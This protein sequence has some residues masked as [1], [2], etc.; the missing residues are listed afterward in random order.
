M[1]IVCRKNLIQND[2]IDCKIITLEEEKKVFL[3]E[4]VNRSQCFEIQN[5]LGG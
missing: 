3:V 5:K 1:P 2:L 4:S